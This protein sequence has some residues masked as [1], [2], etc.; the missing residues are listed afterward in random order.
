MAAAGAQ[1]ATAV[2]VV[3]VMAPL[4]EVGMEIRIV[5]QATGMAVC[6]GAV[7][8]EATETMIDCDGELMVRNVAR[9][10]SLLYGLARGLRRVV[11]CPRELE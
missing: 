9:G 7:G 2:V 5:E 6:D 10:S 1:A 11:V 3:V 8:E 4:G